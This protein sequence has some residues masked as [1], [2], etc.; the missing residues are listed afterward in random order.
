MLA[1]EFPLPRASL[2]SRSDLPFL[3]LPERNAVRTRLASCKARVPDAV[4]RV[5]R[6]RWSA[7]S[8]AVGSRIATQR[9]APP[10]VASRAYHKLREIALSCALPLETDVSSSLHLCEAPG[11]FVQCVGDLV[12]L[13]EE[14]RW[15]GVSLSGHSCPAWWEGVLSSGRGTLVAGDLL[16]EEVQEEVV[17]AARGGEG[18]VDLVTADGAVEMDH[19]CLE[20]AHWPLLLA[21]TKV[22]L[23]CLRPG[24][25]YVVKF[26]EGYERDTTQVWI[27]ALTH[28]FRAVSVIK[29]TSSRV[30]NSERYL[31][32]RGR[33]E[34]GEGD[35]LAC[36]SCPA[37]V[38]SP[39][40]TRELEGQVLDVLATEQ[41]VALERALAMLA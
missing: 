26:F 31:V 35:A 38:V 7:C 12:S 33:R 30:T 11:G 32:C 16:R 27:A 2:G 25:T 34:G 9:L 6:G 17:L 41:C 36:A 5:G 29:P 28:C 10:R 23:R 19:S 8:E 13:P 3:S 1:V 20:E 40:W 24:G 14:W 39:L 21:Q 22:A 15:T 4:A 37:A 18:G